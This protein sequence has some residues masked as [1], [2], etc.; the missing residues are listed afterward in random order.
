MKPFLL[1]YNW[2]AG[3]VAHCSQSPMNKSKVWYK[4]SNFYSKASLGEEV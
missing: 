1:S 4:K 2:T 3:S